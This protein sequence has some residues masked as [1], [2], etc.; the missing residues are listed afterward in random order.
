MPAAKPATRPQYDLAQRVAQAGAKRLE[1][2]GEAV[3]RYVG[4]L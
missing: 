4:S 3:D 1:F 2:P